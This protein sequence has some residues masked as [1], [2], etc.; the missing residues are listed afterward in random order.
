M[1]NVVVIG[2]GHGLSTIMNGIRDIEDISISAIVTVADDGGSTGRLRQRYSIPAMGDIRNV[3]VS[4]SEG[5][6]LLQELMNYRFEGDDDEDISGHSLG[7]LI[8]TALT[9][10]TGSFSDAINLTAF[11]FFVLFKPINI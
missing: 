3:L 8:L 10:M 2:G 5:E 6:P 4:L 11:T 7:N 1:K 9:K